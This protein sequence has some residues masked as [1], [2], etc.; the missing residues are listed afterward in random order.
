MVNKNNVHNNTTSIV[1][2][3]NIHSPYLNWS[4]FR[5]SYSN[6]CRLAPNPYLAWQCE[7]SWQESC[8][9][10]VGI[11]SVKIARNPSV[12][13]FK[14]LPQKFKGYL[15]TLS[16]DSV[17]NQSA[18]KEL[19]MRD[20]MLSWMRRG[21]R[22]FF[23]QHWNKQKFESHKGGCA[24][25]LLHATFKT[26]VYELFLL[27]S[28]FVFSHFVLLTQPKQSNHGFCSKLSISCTCNVM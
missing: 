26:G 22:L 20:S 11:C 17:T 19:L 4:K 23:V 10:V 3:F 2:C 28:H 18:E 27:N 21:W 7:A 13:H 1:F 25:K 5:L 12:H 9:K 24:I 16:I 15:M 6:G 14:L 8:V